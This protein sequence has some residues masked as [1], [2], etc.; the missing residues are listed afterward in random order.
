MSDYQVENGS[1]SMTSQMVVLE[2]RQAV[3]AVS[4]AKRPQ[5]F[6]ASA[7]NTTYLVDSTRAGIR[8]ILLRFKNG[9][10]AK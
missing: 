4:D 10:A 7:P 5:N 9:Y 1:G 6:W 8:K 2:P 3:E